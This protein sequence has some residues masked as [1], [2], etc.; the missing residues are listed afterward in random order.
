MIT[1]SRKHLKIF[2]ILSKIAEEVPPV[3]SARIASA[4]VRKNEIISIGINSLK[5]HP[6]QAKFGKNKNAICL[7][8]EV[9]AIK[10]A[11]RVID[12]DELK[13]CSLYVVRRKKFRISHGKYRYVHGMA[14]PCLGCSNCIAT[15]G[16]KN[17]FYTTN[18][19]GGFECL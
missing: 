10:N 1:F 11:L 7:H 4:I 18:E 6:F 15:F 9:S 2:D 5:T 13:K 8:S 3:Q 16:I 19:N 17:V 14:K 12:E